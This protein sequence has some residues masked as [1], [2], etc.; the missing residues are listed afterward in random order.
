MYNVT[1]VIDNEALFNISDNETQSSLI[2]FHDYQLLLAP[3][4]VRRSL[5][6]AQI[7]LFL[8]TTSVYQDEKNYYECY[9][10]I[11]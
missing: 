9:H 10:L 2:W 5:P 4:F 1:F 7:G 8:H 3:Y 6:S 11:Y